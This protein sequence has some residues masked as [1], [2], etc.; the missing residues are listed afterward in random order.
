[1]MKVKWTACV[2]CVAAMSASLAW[3]QTVETGRADE[4]RQ[5]T[6]AVV[7]PPVRSGLRATMRLDGPWDFAVDPKLQG[8]AE[9]WY[10]PGKAAAGVAQDP[11]PRLLGGARRR[12]A[13]PEQR[14]QPAGLRAGQRQA[15]RRLHGGGVVQEGVH[16]SR[17]IG[18]ANR[19]GSRS[20]ASTARAGS[21][22]T[23]ATSATTGPTAA[24]GSTTSPTWSSRAR[25][26]RSPC[27]CE[28]T[29]PAAAANRTACG[30][31]AGCFAAWN[32]TPRRPF[33]IDNVYVEPLLGSKKAA[34]PRYAP[35]YDGRRARRALRGRGP[36][37]H[38]SDNRPAGESRQDVATSAGRS[39]PRSWRVDVP[40]DPFKPWSPESPLLYKA[41]V[42]LKQDGKPI[43][44]WV[45]RFGVKK[46]EVRG[47]DLYL[48]NVATSSAA[49][50]TTTSIR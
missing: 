9:K 16:R 35:Q 38:R 30:C 36:R 14:R 2:I 15:P 1:M 49:A 43:D 4:A 7:N 50:A 27:W 45:E 44:G 6:P 48:N 11:G 29:C 24:R 31:T 41:E 19:S 10:L 18:P 34:A 8:E 25:R 26:P 32:S 37:Q 5:A 28:T 40:L 13:G 22:S 17:R 12:R 33:S 46:Y 23:A 20:A 3:S 39:R 47:G 21:G 42:V